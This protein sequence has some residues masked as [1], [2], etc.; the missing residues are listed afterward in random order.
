[1]GLSLKHRKL[2]VAGALAGT[3]TASLHKADGTELVGNGYSRPAA[4]VTMS[5]EDASASFATTFPAAG[6]GG[7]PDVKSVQLWDS[8]EAAVFASPVV[9]EE[10]GVAIASV[11]EAEVLRITAGT[12]SID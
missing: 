11:A 12:V 1:M 2:A 10:G 9:L 8:A 4:T 6:A 7:W 5:T 3:F